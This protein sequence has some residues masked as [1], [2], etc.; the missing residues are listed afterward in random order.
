[1]IERVREQQVARGD[2]ATIKR[3]MAAGADTDARDNYGRTPLIVATFER[4]YG[5]ARAL[6]HGGAD[7]NAL[8]NSRYDMLTIAA[9]ADDFEMVML[10]IRS[11]A[12]AKLVTS[13]YD[14]TALI[15]SAHLGHVEVVRALIAAGA[16]L[17]HVNNLGWTA[18]I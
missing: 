3:L 12:N 13:P 18:L 1:M 17:D 16:P 14:G 2:P 15:A 10:A 8:E 5:A 11:G 6:I 9:V 4:K 7:I